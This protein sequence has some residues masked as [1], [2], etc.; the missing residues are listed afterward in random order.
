MRYKIKSL[1][2]FLLSL[3]LVTTAVSYSSAKKKH[4]EE[5]FTKE[6]PNRIDCEKFLWKHGHLECTIYGFG[7]HDWDEIYQEQNGLDCIEGVYYPHQI[8]FCKDPKEKLKH[9]SLLGKVESVVYVFYNNQF[10][11]GIIYV[12]DIDNDYL[13]GYLPEKFGNPIGKKK[14]FLGK[15]YYWVI[16]PVLMIHIDKT[17]WGELWVTPLTTPDWVIEKVEEEWVELKQK[18][19]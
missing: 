5:S 14:M 1:F 4:K 8:K 13:R 7:K 16:P 11:V 6:L 10:K 18:L 2:I 3:I 19:K 15:A 12:N 9:L 17:F